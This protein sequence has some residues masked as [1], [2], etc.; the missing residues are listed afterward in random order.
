M[1]GCHHNRSQYKPLRPSCI[2]VVHLPY[3]YVIYSY[4]FEVSVTS[5]VNCQPTCLTALM[6]SV[7]A[8]ISASKAWCFCSLRILSYRSEMLPNESC[9]AIFNFSSIQLSAYKHTRLS[10]PHLTS[11]TGRSHWVR[12]ICSSHTSQNYFQ[13]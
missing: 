4:P 2:T 5:I 11:P 1:C 8:T 12:L 7:F 6:R 9:F 3:S 10:L 13:L